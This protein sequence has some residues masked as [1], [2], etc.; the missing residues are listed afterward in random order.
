MLIVASKL[1]DSSAKNLVHMPC[2]S[3]TSI[4]LLFEEDPELQVVLVTDCVEPVF[5]ADVQRIDSERTFK[6]HVAGTFC[7]LRASLDA[8]CTTRVTAP[9]WQELF[10]TLE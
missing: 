1:F 4:K 9:S 2:P 10:A 8:L 6:T 3:L 5:H 7:L